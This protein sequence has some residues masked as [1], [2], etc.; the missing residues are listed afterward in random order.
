MM[1]GLLRETSRPMRPISLC[2]SPVVTRS[3]VSPPS[4]ERQHA[5]SGSAAREAERAAPPLIHGRDERPAVGR[6]SRCRSRRC[7]RRR[8]STC[9]HVVP[10]SRVRYTPRSAFGPEQV[11]DRGDEHRR[12]GCAGRSTTR[13]DASASR[14][15]PCA[16]TS[17]RRR[18]TCRRR[19]PTWSSAGCSAR[20]CRPTR[21]SDCSARSRCR[22]R[23][24]S[25]STGRTPASHVVPLFATSEHAA[26]CARDED[27][28]RVAGAPP[29]CRRRARRTRPARCGASS[30]RR[31]TGARPGTRARAAA[32][33]RHRRHR[34]SVRAP[35]PRR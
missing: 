10:P 7:S 27:D 23:T 8:A 28:A 6:S 33:R 29:R 30:M 9:C 16:A 24:S 22:R 34:S 3:Q 31:A 2:G 25:R 35:R 17:C 32:A 12:P 19:R 11:P 21:C 18:S 26:R 4:V 13:A 5:A 15:A 20:P 14:A 1:S